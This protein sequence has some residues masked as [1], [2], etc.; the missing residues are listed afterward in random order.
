MSAKVV[1]VH[2]IIVMVPVI[3]NVPHVL[4]TN[5]WLGIILVESVTVH[6]T[7]VLK[8]EPIIVLHVQLNFIIHQK[9]V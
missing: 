7:N 9:L 5:I 2:V 1:T 8:Q 6:V 4:L 3:I